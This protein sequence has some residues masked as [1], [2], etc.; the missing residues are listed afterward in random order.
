FFVDSKLTY[1]LKGLPCGPYALDTDRL[2][3]TVPHSPRSSRREDP[4]LAGFELASRPTRSAAD[5]SGR[6]LPAAVSRQDL[7]AGIQGQGAL[8]PSGARPIDSEDE[9]S[10]RVPEEGSA[11][12]EVPQH[13]GLQTMHS[14]RL[15][16]PETRALGNLPAVAGSFAGL[17]ACP[18]A[19][20]LP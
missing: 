3:T 4:A 10:R 5:S 15:H 16:D 17:A 12:P 20:R 7:T 6:R 13:E 19:R 11:C 2:D 8:Q 1:V 9:Q 18:P 14:D